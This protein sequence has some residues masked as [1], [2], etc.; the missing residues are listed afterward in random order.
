VLRVAAAC[1]VGFVLMN[2]LQELVIY[3]V[4]AYG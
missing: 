2:Q 3:R 1:L 4:A